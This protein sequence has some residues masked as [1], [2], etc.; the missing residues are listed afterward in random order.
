MD[1]R[2][3]GRM[4]DDSSETSPLVNKNPRRVS[5]GKVSNADLAGTRVP[6]SFSSISLA[7][8]NRR[9]NNK[10]LVS[11]T[12]DS[13]GASPSSV[14]VNTEL[15]VDQQAG[16]NV[17]Q[18]GGLNADIPDTIHSQ[19]T[20]FYKFSFLR[21][22]NNRYLIDAPPPYVVYL[23]DVDPEANAGNIHPGV[24]GRLLRTVKIQAV[25]V[26][27]AGPEKTVISFATAQLG[28][29]FVEVGINSLNPN[30]RAI[31]PNSC[32]FNVGI[33]QNFPLDY[34][35]EIFW[36][37]LAE[38]DKELIDRVEFMKRKKERKVNG[39]I[40]VTYESIGSA[41]VYSKGDLPLDICV[42]NAFKV[43]DKWVPKIKRCFRCQRYGHLNTNCD[44][45]LRC[46]R[47]GQDHYSEDCE[48][49]QP[50]CANCRGNHIASDKS[51][52][53]YCYNLDLL[54]TKAKLECSNKEAARLTSKKYLSEFN[55][56]INDEVVVFSEQDEN[57][58]IANRRLPE[59]L[60]SMNSRQSFQASGSAR[61][62]QKKVSANSGSNETKSNQL[63]GSEDR[64]SSK[65]K[66]SQEIL[67]II[68]P[69]I[70]D[71]AKD[72]PDLE[73]LFTSFE[74]TLVN[75]VTDEDPENED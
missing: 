48:N 29:S 5:P 44:H 15:V 6:P 64:R 24:I 58:F 42:Y 56:W 10:S 40:I 26:T 70:M 57:S 65:F 37:G 13:R 27:S 12:G 68:K 43:I 50:S 63:G 39:K 52:V 49:I 18:E 54:E 53:V 8:D 14:I 55:I 31:I 4:G 9:D 46:L 30:W 72:N 51:C 2:K 25:L 35:E 19:P 60:K 75:L 71:Q 21:Q 34:T 16:I 36:E 7:I 62:D 1:N 23:I 22:N 66:L 45:P 61:P 32:I 33:T 38:E 74:I 28:N 47:C 20:G 73:H 17:N 3:R 59:A 69:V 67:G 11:S 41:K